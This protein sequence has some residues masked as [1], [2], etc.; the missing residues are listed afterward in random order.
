MDGGGVRALFRPHR[1]LGSIPP[2][3]TFFFAQQTQKTWSERGAQAPVDV[4][5]VGALSESEFGACLCTVW[6]MQSF[7]ALSKM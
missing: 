2:I 3:F 4:V 7:W 5:D 6:G 1:D